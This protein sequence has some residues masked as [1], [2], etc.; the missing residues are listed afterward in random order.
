MTAS[1]NAKWKKSK[2]QKATNDVI[3]LMY[4]SGKAN[5]KHNTTEIRSVVA[6]GVVAG[7]DCKRAQEIWGMGDAEMFCIFIVVMVTQ[8]HTFVKTH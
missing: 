7:A 2:T 6:W 8:L 3:L 1:Q 4:Y 5:I